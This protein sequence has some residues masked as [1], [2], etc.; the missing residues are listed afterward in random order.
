MDF[1]LSGG[2][3]CKQVFIISPEY[4]KISSQVFSQTDRGATLIEA[5]GMYSKNS[6]PI[7]LCVVAKKKLQN[8]QDL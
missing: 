4:E 2:K 5:K 7:L 6:R 8:L 3:A 1:I